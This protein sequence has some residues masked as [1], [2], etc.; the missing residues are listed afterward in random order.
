L[1]NQFPEARS[2]GAWLRSG[3]HVALGYVLGFAVLI[4]VMGWHPTPL[5][6]R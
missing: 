5:G 1:S 4:A 2:V 6:A 3:W